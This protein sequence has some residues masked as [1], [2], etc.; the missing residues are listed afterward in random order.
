MS[1]VWMSWS[2]HHAVISPASGTVPSPGMSTVRPIASAVS[3]FTE[4]ARAARH[5]ASGSPLAISP[6][7]DV[8]GAHRP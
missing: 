2:F 1:Q 3:A 7:R 8:P 6:G 5:I 4:S